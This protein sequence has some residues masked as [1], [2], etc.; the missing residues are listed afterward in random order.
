MADIQIKTANLFLP[1]LA[2]KTETVNDVTFSV[3]SNGVIT[4]NGTASANAIFKYE[5]KDDMSIPTSVREGGNAYLYF[6]NNF[7]TSSAIVR[8]YNGYTLIEYW[9]MNSINRIRDYFE[10]LENKTINAVEIVIYS[11]YTAIDCELSV[12][13]TDDGEQAASFTPYWKHSLKKFDGAAW[14][15]ATVHEF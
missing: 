12:M 5:L 3:D 8:F 14:Q 7:V 13:L 15:N 1:P 11:G 4:I 2:A 6:W 10:N 9:T